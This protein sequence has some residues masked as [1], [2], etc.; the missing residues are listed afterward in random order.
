[1]QAITIQQNTM[2][3]DRIGFN[4]NEYNTI[5][6]NKFKTNTKLRKN[7][8]HHRMTPCIQFLTSVCSCSTGSLL[9]V[10]GGRRSRALPILQGEGE[11]RT[12]GERRR[13]GD[14]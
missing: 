5:N 9:T 10:L 1:M 13:D 11:G 6:E 4:G 3:Y 14:W 12:G 7:T 2:R 8:A